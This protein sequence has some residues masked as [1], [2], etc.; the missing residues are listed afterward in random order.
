MIGIKI[1]KGAINSKTKLLKGAI[2]SH[3]NLTK[4]ANYDIILIVSRDWRFC[5]MK[6]I[7]LQ[8]LIEWNENK[9]RKPLI[10]WGARQF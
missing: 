2:N 9:K 8:S 3:K 10:V 4:G 1:K 6:R 7:A 5:F